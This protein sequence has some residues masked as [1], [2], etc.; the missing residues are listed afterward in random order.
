MWAY[1]FEGFQ[2]LCSENLITSFQ[3]LYIYNDISSKMWTI[4]ATNFSRISA[5]K[6]RHMRKAA[7]Y[8]DRLQTNKE[9]TEELEIIPILEVYN[10]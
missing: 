2:S 7:S 8:M 1:I 3:V 10:M 5:T 9:I 4:R 6:M